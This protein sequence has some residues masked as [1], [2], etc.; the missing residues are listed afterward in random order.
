MGYRLNAKINVLENKD[1]WVTSPYGQ[2]TDP[3]SGAKSF[4]NGIDLISESTGV[5]D[6]I[7]F[8]DGVVEA[9]QTC[10]KGK[11]TTVYTA[12]NYVKIKHNSTYSSRY[13]HLKY[14]SISL[15][16][17]DKV[18]KGQKIGVMGSTGYSTG[19]HLHFDMWENGERIDP[20]PFLK[21]EKSINGEEKTDIDEKDLR[22]GDKVTLKNAPLFASST[23]KKKANTISGTYYVFCDGVINKRVRVTT[24][25]GC[26]DCT[27]WVYVA[28][29]GVKKA[30]NNIKVGDTVKVK[31]G[32]KSYE[33]KGLATFVY[34]QKYVVIEL[35]R[36]RAV[37][38]QN[39]NVTAA[40]NI[41][42][43]YEV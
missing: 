13:L 4:H 26:K 19:N 41:N 31:A 35:V 30:D 39:G 11:D 34:T 15:K 7:A 5:D 43:L 36:D 29:C 22:K 42:D 9:V 38:G 2:R 8:A 16:V 14:G 1:E 32:A 27:G 25:K 33:G 18:K 28:D 6:I 10:V 23:A 17:G 20:T 40:V 12:G 21:G 3:I 24:P 37:I